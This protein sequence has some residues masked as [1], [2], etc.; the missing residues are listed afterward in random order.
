MD[1]LYYYLERLEEAYGVDISNHQEYFAIHEAQ[2]KMETAISN[3]A[4]LVTQLMLQQ[5]C[6]TKRLCSE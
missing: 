1:D 6:Q 4:V 2:V 3:V 5:E